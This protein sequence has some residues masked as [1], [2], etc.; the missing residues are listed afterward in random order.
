[1]IRVAAVQFT[2]SADRVDNLNTCLG[3]IDAAVEGQAQLV[4]L[5]HLNA[6]G[7]EFADS[8]EAW[9]MALC[10]DD[11]LLTAIASKARKHG[12]YIVTAATLRLKDSHTAETPL[13]F[14]PGEHS[15]S[16][17]EAASRVHLGQ[18][19]CVTAE[20]MPRVVDTELGR[21]GV[22]A[23]GDVCSFDTARVL[24]LQGAQIL[25][26]SMGAAIPPHVH[27]HHPVRSAENR[28][29]LIAAT[30]LQDPILP[31]ATS[32]V[33]TAEPQAELMECRA[34]QIISPKGQVLAH[35]LDAQEGVIWAE[36]EPAEA[37]RKL[38]P[39]GSDV[40]FNRRPALYGD[41]ALPS[42]DEFGQRSG[43][44]VL[45]AEDL[46]IA[47]VSVDAVDGERRLRQALR[48]ISSLP[49]TVRL[50][51]LPELF[52][53]ESTSVYPLSDTLELSRQVQAEL[54]QLCYQRQFH[55]CTSLIMASHNGLQH[56]GV[57]LGPQS[58]EILQPQL[59][60]SARYGW[61]QAGEKLMIA[62]LPWG[63]T[64]VLTG[65]DGCYPELVKLAAQRGVQ[66][67]L[68]TCNCQEDWEL[69]S[70]FLS[71][72]A[73]HR[74]SVIMCSRDSEPVC[75][76]IASA[77]GQRVSSTR[78]S[79]STLLAR[80]EPVA[81]DCVTSLSSTEAARRRASLLAAELCAPN[82]FDI[83]QS[84]DLGIFLV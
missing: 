19:P 80:L 23:A 50:V 75:G 46:G 14:G 31:T 55:I 17:V 61:H 42:T 57:L 52:W 49:D 71:R 82:P 12:C 69:R 41:I 25:C 76:L 47:M 51:M 62:D 22:L 44:L 1:M 8:T 20:R 72:A 30:H 7:R 56:C 5:P 59:H 21:I 3:L 35:A 74:I 40:F 27:L 39:D 43:D 81:G 37:D 13:L 34:S 65:D 15:V 11:P 68:I 18:I 53:L 36:I 24:A 64:A 10:P 4:V 48:A 77:E 78:Q 26:S 66:T 9:D 58:I 29:F 32:W 79:A 83:E 63:R 2:S 38:R 73:E 70:G 45:A 28:V 84:D 33:G 16:D 6:A 67:L 54:L 60:F